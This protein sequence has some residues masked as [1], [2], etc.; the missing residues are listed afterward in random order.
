MKLSSPKTQSAFTLIELLVVISIIAILAGIALPV[1]GEVQVK[2]A[3]SKIL[4]NIKQVGLACRL[5]ADDYDGLFPTNTID[6]ATGKLSKNEVSDSNT[7][8]AQLFEAGYMKSEQLFFCA[9]SKWT[10]TP[11]DEK[12]GTGSTLTTGENHF[13]YVLNL[14]TTSN[15]AYPLIADGFKNEGDHT[16][17]T[18]EDEKGGVWKGK[19]AIVLHC[20]NSGSIEKLN[21]N[22]KV[23]GGSKG[24]DL[25][26]NSGGTP[27]VPW[28]GST[29]KVVNPK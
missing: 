9:K 2:G 14:T 7:A 8:F 16:Y 23:P 24:D 17:S 19:K 21:K 27:D 1:F 12:M 5:F 20:D 29:N 11:P 28:M 26:E 3:Q 22:L 6:E 10:P 25:F 18:K 4:S 15:A 13:A